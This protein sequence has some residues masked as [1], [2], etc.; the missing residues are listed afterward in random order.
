MV[1]ASTPGRNCGDVFTAEPSEVVCQGSWWCSS[2]H[3]SR[4]LGRERGA[5]LDECASVTRFVIRRALLPTPPDDADVSEYLPD[6]NMHGNAVSVRRL[7]DHTS[8][9]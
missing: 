2:L 1:L 6:F 3:R 5:A 7:L 4:E 8:G 9:I